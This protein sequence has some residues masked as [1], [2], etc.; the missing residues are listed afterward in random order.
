M[1]SFKLYRHVMSGHSH[2]VQVF[3]S[4]LGLEAE[5][6][7]VNLAKGEHKSA[8]YLQKNIF[9]QVPVLEINDEGKEITLADSNAILIY[10]ASQ[11]DANRSWYPEDL[12]QACEVQRFLSVAAGKIAY[13]PAN[14]RLVNVFGAAIDHEY[15]KNVAHGIL[16]QLEHHLQGRDWLVGDSATIADVANYT[17]IALAP[18]GDVSLAN[19]PNIR[20][21]LKRFE[22]LKGFVTM[23]STAVGLN[24]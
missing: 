8:K 24:A 5:L 13:G 3:L 18:E 9:S 2:R 1:A 15:A 19:Y 23:K 7:D 12:E 4:L 10:L 21:W 14:A 20:A 17:Y 16:S 6:V 11:Y 22:N